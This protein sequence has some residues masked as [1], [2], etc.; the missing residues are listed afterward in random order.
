MGRSLRIEHLRAN[1]RSGWLGPFNGRFA[2]VVTGA[3]G[4]ASADLPRGRKRPGSRTGRGG[5]DG[6]LLFRRSP[7]KKAK[8]RSQS[9]PSELFFILPAGAAVISKDDCPGDERL[10]TNDQHWFPVTNVHNFKIYY[11]SHNFGNIFRVGQGCRK[12][13]SF[14]TVDAVLGS[15]LGGGRPRVPR[16]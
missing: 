14:I 12:E 5:F 3:L 7:P 16:I 11:F 6:I 15:Q 4:P 1:L 9:V 8:T 13:E 2:E 10:S